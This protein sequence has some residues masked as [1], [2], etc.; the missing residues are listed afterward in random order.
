MSGF[1]RVSRLKCI[2]NKCLA[3]CMW[4]AN[5]REQGRAEKQGKN[6]KNKWSREA[7]KSGKVGTRRKA[8]KRR[9]RTTEK[10]RSRKAVL[11]STQWFLYNVRDNAD[12][13]L[14]LD[15]DRNAHLLHACFRERFSKQQSC[16]VLAQTGWARSEP[17][18]EPR[19]EPT[20][21]GV[22]PSKPVLLCDRLVCMGALLWNIDAPSFTK[23]ANYN[24]RLHLLTIHQSGQI[25]QVCFGPLVPSRFICGADHMP[26]TK[27]CAS[28][29]FQG[30]TLFE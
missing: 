12:W 26:K 4:K 8:E 3:V 23:C 29:T 9:G 2:V 11:N 19:C 30:C 25:G 22:S 28:S 20:F 15:V 1:K 16:L 6:R 24:I 7:R 21:L 14:C 10:Q 27:H 17:R 5:R 18:R 13:L